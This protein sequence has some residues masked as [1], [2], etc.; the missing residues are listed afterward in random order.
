MAQHQ[1]PASGKKVPPNFTPRMLTTEEIEALRQ[2]NHRRHKAN[3]EMLK[4]MDL[5]R[6]ME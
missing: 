2:D 5:S 4:S 1:K 6:L 3:M